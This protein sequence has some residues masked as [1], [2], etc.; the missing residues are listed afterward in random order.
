M[1]APENWT[2]PETVPGVAP[3]PGQAGCE[4]GRA[5]LD[6]R[7]S[8]SFRFA[9]PSNRPGAF[10]QRCFQG[11]P[12]RPAVKL[13]APAR[14]VQDVRFTSEP[15]APGRPPLFYDSQNPENRAETG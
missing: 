7:C 11:Y 12:I 6:I 10:L 8:L 5:I 4:I 13:A 9:R 1:T 3:G 15:G 14:R 2:K